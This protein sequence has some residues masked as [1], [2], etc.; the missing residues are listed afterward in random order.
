MGQPTAPPPNLADLPG[1][2]PLLEG[3]AAPV[4]AAV[5]RAGHVR[6][7]EAGATVFAEG[8]PATSCYV[9]L[10]GSVKLVQLTEDGEAIVFRLLGFGDAFGTIAILGNGPYPVSAS[11][12]TAI[13]T[14]QW[15]ANVMRQ[16]LEQ[17]SRL[18]LNVL[19]SVSERLQAL[20]LQYRQLATE[21][22]ERR[23]AR[24]LLK[25]V[26]RAGTRVTDGVLLDLPL[27]RED[28]A[29]LTGTTVY[30]VSRIIS[31]WE[32][33][34]VLRAGRQQLIIRQPDVLAS[35]ADDME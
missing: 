27:S 23:I 28:V 1:S 24:A 10:T 32:S 13:T 33:S 29:Q 17:H 19:R 3:L 8:Q 34:G 18:S 26:E 15:P 2:L 14:L 30:T 21:K 11:A 6:H 35:I 16:L 22:V 12:V 9:L 20:R 31:R 5:V 4:A 7:F 25:L